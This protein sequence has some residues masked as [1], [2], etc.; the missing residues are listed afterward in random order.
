M[1]DDEKIR[2]ALEQVTRKA[3]L[4]AERAGFALQPDHAQRDHV[5][6]SLARN[7]LKHGKPYCP[8]REV[9]GDPEKDRANICPCRTHRE[10]IER[11]GQCEC[12][13]FV[14]RKERGNGLHD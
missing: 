13:L 5:L 11:D 4:Y 10:D 2:A 9:S 12:S 3:E 1:A 6:R 7:L 8:C 14:Q